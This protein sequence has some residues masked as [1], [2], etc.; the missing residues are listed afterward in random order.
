MI[1]DIG[2]IVKWLGVLFTIGFVSIPTSLL[3]FKKHQ[4]A[5]L[6]FAKILGVILLSYIVFCFSI[7]R[8]LP[9]TFS[10]IFIGLILWSGFNL[11]LFVKNQKTISTAFKEKFPVF[12]L[13]EILFVGITMLWIY[14]RGN[15]PDIRGLEKFMDYGFVNALLKSEYLPPYD[16]WFAGKF[17]NYYWFGHF[18]TALL[19]KLSMIPSQITYNLMMATLAGLVFTSAFSLVSELLKDVI[20]NKRTHVLGGILA[21]LLLVFGGNLHTPFYVLKEGAAKYWYPDATR[22]IGYNPETNDKTIHEFPNYSFVVS[23]LHAHVINLPFVLLFL[24]TL[25]SLVSDSRQK[26]A[27][28]TLLGFLLGTFFMTNTWDFG[29]Y[30]LMLGLTLFIFMLKDKLSPPV[31]VKNIGAV[32]FILI[33][34][35]GVLLPFVLNFESIAQG[36]KLVHTHTPLWQLV[37]LWGFPF[38]IFTFYGLFVLRGLSKKTV[39]AADLFAVSLF[40]MGIIL[41]ALPEIMYVKDIYVATHYR[42]NTMFKLTYQAFVMFYLFA[43][44]AL[45]RILQNIKSRYTELMFTLIL[46][47]LCSS[48]L[49]YSYFSIG[50]YYNKLEL[51]KGLDGTSWITT[52]LPERAELITWIKENVTDQSILLEA[53]GDSYTDFNVVSSYTGLPTVS[54]WFVHEWLWRGDSSFPQERV[55]DI[56]TIYTSQDL[57]LT[58]SLLVKYGIN[59]VIVGNQEREKF[60]TLIEKKFND[61]GERIFA[62]QTSSIFKID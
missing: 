35:G 21:G 51:Y 30:L 8:F 57:A 26:V 56:Q 44:F 14:I 62:N 39:T 20:E 12:I 15:Q 18:I 24:M 31:F 33:I 38:I 11:L 28:L 45:F 37:I 4:T 23:D 34:A 9:F 32:I 27:K 16:M 29:T 40:I 17:I 13:Q 53:P 48:I 7:F 36:I 5:G 58:K 2:F 47:V 10:T 25:Y 60:P 46:S 1:N 61:L 3:L 22:F 49:S 55:T 19:T 6:G 41:V 52:Y 54:G 43:G 59:Y 42:A 50:S